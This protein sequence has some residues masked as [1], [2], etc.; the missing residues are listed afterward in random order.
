M[1]PK[2][3]RLRL[4]V[5]PRGQSDSVGSQYGRSDG[6]GPVLKT[7]PG[8]GRP[9]SMGSPASARST[10][11]RWAS[12]ASGTIGRRSSAPSTGTP[13][14]RSASQIP[15]PPLAICKWYVD[16]FFTYFP[17]DDQDH[18][19]WRGS[20]LGDDADSGLCPRSRRGLAGRLARRFLPSEHLPPGFARWCQ[21][22][23]L[24]DGPGLLRD[25]PSLLQP[26]SDR[27]TDHRQ[28]RAP[29]SRLRRR[30]SIPRKSP[31]PSFPWSGSC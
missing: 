7:S 29:E 15:M 19:K 28:F 14:D 30:G 1:A 23:P 3:G 12:G 2:S 25:V 22:Y 31:R 18:G 6:Q 9:A 27:P 8:L 26:E 24:A 10:S 21:R 5:Q 20:W 13:R 11:A 4:H 17:Q 16:E